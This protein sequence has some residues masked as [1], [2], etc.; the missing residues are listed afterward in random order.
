MGDTIPQAV[1]EH[2]EKGKGTWAPEFI[3][4]CFPTADAM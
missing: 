4:L 1:S 3:A 2:D